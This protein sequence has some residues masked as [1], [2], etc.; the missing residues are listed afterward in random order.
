MRTK[1]NYLSVIFG[2]SFMI[3]SLTKFTCA[4]C[5]EGTIENSWA[6]VDEVVLSLPFETNIIKEKKNALLL[7]RQNTGFSRPFFDN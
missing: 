4:F 7:V 5:Q 3:Q 2:K 6:I 1:E